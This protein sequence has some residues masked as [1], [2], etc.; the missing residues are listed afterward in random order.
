MS[1]DSHLNNETLNSR[2]LTVTSFLNTYKQSNIYLS[3]NDATTNDSNLLNESFHMNELDSVLNSVNK[4]SAPGFDEICY[5]YLTNLPDKAKYYYLSI[6]N[7]SWENNV[8]PDIW[9]LAIVKPIF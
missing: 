4:R 5:Q 2:N 9:K 6:L 3:L 1:S 8:I 7:H